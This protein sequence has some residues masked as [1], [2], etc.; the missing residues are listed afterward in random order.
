[1]KYLRKFNEELRAETYTKAA[2][3]L[4]KKGHKKSRPNRTAFK[5]RIK[6]TKIL[7]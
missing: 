1:M 5:F 7:F 2:R 6:R 3:L 4:N